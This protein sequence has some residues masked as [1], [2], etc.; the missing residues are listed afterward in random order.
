MSKIYRKILNKKYNLSKSPKIKYDKIS[1]QIFPNT[2]NKHKSYILDKLNIIYNVKIF[3]M[4]SIGITYNGTNIVI[5]LSYENEKENERGS[6]TLIYLSQLSF[7]SLVYN[8][9]NFDHIFNDEQL[10]I[11]D[12]IFEILNEYRIIIDNCKILSKFNTCDIIFY[13]THFEKTGNN[14][15][16]NVIEQ[17]T[18][19]INNISN[20]QLIEDIVNN[21]F[22]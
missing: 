7:P 1:N 5:A 6:I 19:F 12:N 14:I 15:P 11:P 4:F 21:F 16:N 22:I 20:K 9:F 2:V 17:F 3:Y 13:L 8:D 18:N 10:S